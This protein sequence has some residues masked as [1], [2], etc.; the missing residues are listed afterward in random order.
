MTLGSAGQLTLL[1]FQTPMA[2]GDG[3]HCGRPEQG[4]VTGQRDQRSGDNRADGAR[5]DDGDVDDA[6]VLWPGPWRPAAPA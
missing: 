5:A 3:H 1:I 4:R 6:E 2:G